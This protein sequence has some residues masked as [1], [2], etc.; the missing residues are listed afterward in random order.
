[1][2]IDRISKEELEDCK[3]SPLYFYN[4]YIRKSEDPELSQ[5]EFDTMIKIANAKNR[6][7]SNSKEIIIIDDT[8]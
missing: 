7:K 1:M 2:P 8:E 5:A 4:K 3:R 6:K